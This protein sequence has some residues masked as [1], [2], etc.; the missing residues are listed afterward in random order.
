MN[1]AAPRPP[2]RAPRSARAAD[3]PPRARQM[4]W[5]RFNANTGAEV[6][7]EGRFGDID[8]YIID[9]LGNQVYR[10]RSDIPE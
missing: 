4:H 7:N 1:H 9:P 3:L 6:S 5:F 2:A 8:G 10:E